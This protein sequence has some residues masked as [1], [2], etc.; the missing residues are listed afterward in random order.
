MARPPGAPR[1]IE[2]TAGQRRIAGWFAAAL[3]IGIVALAFRIL[4]GN[5]DGAAIDPDPSSSSGPAPSIR[6]GTAL[7][8]A[9]GAVMEGSETDRFGEG[10]LFAYSLQVEGSPPPQVF[11]EVRRTGGGPIE[12][13][14][15]PIDAQALPDPRI[16]AFAVLADALI[17]AFGA[18]SYEMTIYAEPEGEPLG[19]GRFELVGVTVSPAASP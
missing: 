1:R 17:A 5:G 2:L 19:S 13:V 12:A 16:I 11:V 9:T 7:D 18:G 8:Q 14:Q 3:L 15:D 10:D 6:F 4:G